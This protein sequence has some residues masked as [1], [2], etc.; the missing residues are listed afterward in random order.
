VI[1]LVNRAGEHTAFP[2]NLN[3]KRPV[4]HAHFCIHILSAR[5]LTLMSLWPCFQSQSAIDRSI[6][7]FHEI[8]MGSWSI[9]LA[10]MATVCTYNLNIRLIVPY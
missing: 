1:K 9:F 4:Y 2:R 7:L 10:R 6:Q 8:S 3:D 5:A